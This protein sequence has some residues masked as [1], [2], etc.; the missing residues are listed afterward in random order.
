MQV[1]ILGFLRGKL[2]V[3]FCNKINIFC[4]RCPYYPKHRGKG[5]ESNRNLKRCFGY[6]GR[7]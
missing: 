4:K 5:A 6:R 7:P 1:G 3:Y 2:G